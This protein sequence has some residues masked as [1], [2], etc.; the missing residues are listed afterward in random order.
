[1]TALYE[2]YAPWV[3]IALLV[4]RSGMEKDVSFMWYALGKT[5]GRLYL[6]LISDFVVVDAQHVPSTGPVILASNHKSN[7]DPFCVAAAVDRQVHFLAKDE[8]FS[9]PI[10]GWYM[11]RTGAIPVKRGGSDRRAVAAASELLRQGRVIGIFVEG[12]RRKDIEGLGAL[13]A[14]A[15]MLRQRTNA[16]IVPEAINRERLHHHLSLAPPIVAASVVGSNEEVSRKAIYS[17]INEAISDA[18]TLMLGRSYAT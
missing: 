2:M 4:Q 12:T 14:G 3:P 10:V 17:R 18:L 13:R 5:V 1:M 16:P 15:T 6:G 9:T 8:L 11:R 7:L